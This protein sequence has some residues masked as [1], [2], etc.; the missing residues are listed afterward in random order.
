MK[1]SLQDRVVVLASGN[2]GKLR[3]LAG[4]LAPLGLQLKPQADFEV[5]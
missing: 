2:S 1:R 5:P 3:E 4:I